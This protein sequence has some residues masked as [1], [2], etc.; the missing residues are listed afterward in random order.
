MI[1]AGEHVHDEAEYLTLLAA[2]TDLAGRITGAG[3]DPA[4][5]TVTIYSGR[6]L[7]VVQLTR[8]Y[9]VKAPAL[10]LLHGQS[11]ALIERF[12][13]VDLLWKQPSA[14]KSLFRS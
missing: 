10:Q 3:R 5:Y 9:E 4:R 11:C 13:R 2:L 8:G 7:V 1:H 6:E 14:I 12:A